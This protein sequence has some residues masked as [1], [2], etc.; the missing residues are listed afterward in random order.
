[1]KGSNIS[2]NKVLFWITNANWPD[3]FKSVDK[4]T[5]LEKWDKGTFYIDADL[6]IFSYAPKS[7]KARQYA[8]IKL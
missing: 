1:M 4:P 8:Y 7:T 3:N 2:K 6:C 5:P